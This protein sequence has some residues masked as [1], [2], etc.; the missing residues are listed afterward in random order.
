M[1]KKRAHEFPRDHG[2]WEIEYLNWDRLFNEMFA[3]E[4][5]NNEGQHEETYNK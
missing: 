3:L 1:F 2:K 4:K 5:R